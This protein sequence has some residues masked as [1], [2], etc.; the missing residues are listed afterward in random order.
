LKKQ[1]TFARLR[2]RMKAAPPAGR[3]FGWK[4]R[5]DGWVFRTKAA[6]G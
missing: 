2:Q 6:D 3:F 4:K 1:A 5:A